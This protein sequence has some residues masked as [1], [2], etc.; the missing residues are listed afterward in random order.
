MHIFIEAII[1]TLSK[2]ISALQSVIY[3]MNREISVQLQ[4]V[5]SAV[6]K[7]ENDI[8]SLQEGFS[9]LASFKL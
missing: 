5:A 9:E 7:A 3:R 4:P 6:G 1:G 8:Q 2:Q